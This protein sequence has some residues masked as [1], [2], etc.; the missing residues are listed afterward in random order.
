[1][2]WINI[3]RNSRQL[4]DYDFVKCETCKPLSNCISICT[5]PINT[6]NSINQQNY[7]DNQTSSDLDAYTERRKL[8]CSE[9]RRKASWKNNSNLINSYRS[10]TTPYDTRLKKRQVAYSKPPW[11]FSKYERPPEVFLN[12]SQHSINNKQVENASKRETLKSATRRRPH[13]THQQDF[14]RLGRKS[15]VDQKKCIRNQSSDESPSDHYYYNQDKFTHDKN[16]FGT[17]SDSS[18]TGFGSTVNVGSNPRKSVKH[19]KGGSHRSISDFCPRPASESTNCMHDKVTQTSSVSR[20][21]I[22]DEELPRISPLFIE[23]SD[24]C[25]LCLYRHLNKVYG[26]RPTTLNSSLNRK[27]SGVFAVNYDTTGQDEVCLNS[28]NLK[29]QFSFTHETNISIPSSTSIERQACTPVNQQSPPYLSVNDTPYYYYSRSPNSCCSESRLHWLTA[30]YPVCNPPYCSELTNSQSEVTAVSQTSKHLDQQDGD[31]LLNR[32]KLKD[33]HTTEK[34]PSKDKL[35]TST[36]VNV[37][38][39]RTFVSNQKQHHPHYH[40][41]Q[42]VDRNTQEH[43]TTSSNT[44]NLVC[45]KNTAKTKST[46]C[47]AHNNHQNDQ[48]HWSHVFTVYSS[49][50]FDDNEYIISSCKHMPIMCECPHDSTVKSNHV[51]NTNQNTTTNEISDCGTMHKYHLVHWYDLEK[52]QNAKN[53][54]VV[55]D[56]PEK[57]R[58]TGECARC[59]CHQAE[60]TPTANTTPANNNKNYNN[61]SN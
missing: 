38:A 28:S 23:K 53:G 48:S 9:T 17:S 54:K 13:S 52:N 27:N 1:M 26:K 37:N 41:Y 61:N 58:L 59:P 30:C 45:L 56:S 32:F 10:S 42:E 21:S 8:S 2:H 16:S 7:S 15:L 33:S 35:L 55:S 50:P 11:R 25:S 3:L 18:S 24:T 60:N 44:T 39:N 29:K 31:K 19:A 46:N 14:S 22:D 34:Y 51:C 49:K 20:N 12:T 57:N 6:V 5:R 40:Q 43:N 36:N 47:P 4:K